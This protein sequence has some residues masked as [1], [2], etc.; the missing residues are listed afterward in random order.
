VLKNRKNRTV[1]VRDV[2]RLKFSFLLLFAFASTK[3]KRSPAFG[4]INNKMEDTD[5]H[6]H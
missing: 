4:T 6:S 3:E 2:A 1:S 5:G